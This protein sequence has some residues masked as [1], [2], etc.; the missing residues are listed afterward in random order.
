MGHELAGTEAVEGSGV[1][2]FLFLIFN[3]YLLLLFSTSSSYICICY[4][5][6]FLVGE[7]ES[8]MLVESMCVRVC[9]DASS[10]ILRVKKDG[11]SFAKGK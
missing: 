11:S 10:C 9:Q 2:A 5:C 3:I 6:S 4:S 1:R 7:R 8:A